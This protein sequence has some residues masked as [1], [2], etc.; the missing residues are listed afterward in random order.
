VGIV[1]V[2]DSAWAKEATKWE[3]QGSTMGP[4][5]RPYVKRD[6]PMMLHKAWQKPTGGIDILDQQIVDDADQRTRLE[7]EGY[8]AT[9]L[10]A[11]DALAAQQVE[12]AKLAAEREYEK[13]HRLSARAAAEVTLAEADAG[14]QHLPTIPE[15]PIRR[16]GRP[17][18][19]ETGVS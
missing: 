5:L 19:V 9:P 4:G 1:H 7:A 8:R 3:A 6:Y 18:K 17:K 12:F 10:E 15:T 13:Q 14:A 16:R 2:P 11:M